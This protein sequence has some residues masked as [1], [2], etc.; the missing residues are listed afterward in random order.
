MTIRKDAVERA[1]SRRFAAWWTVPLGI[2]VTSRLFSIGVV[3]AL[4]AGGHARGAGSALT[5]W[6]SEWYLRI[7]SAGYHAAVVDGGHDYAFYPG[8]PIL[9]RLAS[10][11]G[12]SADSAAVVLANLLFVVA[13]VLVWR[14]LEAR[15][16]GQVASGATA[17]L[18]FAPPAFVFSLAYSEPL[19]LFAAA[20]FFVVPP[21]SAWRLPVAS[22]AMLARVGGIGIVA[23]GC[24]AALRESGRGRRVAIL[25]VLAGLG[26]FAAWWLYIA[27]L[28]GDPLGYLRGSTAWVHAGAV[29]SILRTTYSHPVT[30]AAWAAFVGV[31]IVGTWL[32]ARRDR[33]LFA[34]AVVTLG[35]GALPVIGGGLLHSVPRYALVAFPAFAG[36]AERLGRRGTIALVVVFALAQVAFA[37]WAVPA[38][39]SQSP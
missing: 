14:V 1:G 32:I 30:V 6:D 5:I 2:A 4:A 37:A 12:I 29:T 33:E 16:D 20:L 23:A 13:A 10:L 3:L 25:V 9:I 18:A 27:L 26:T 15:F 17:L 8:W 31:V 36:V 28:T 34:F 21:R 24:A 38:I 22:I 11:T 19:F 7:A 39:G 35:L